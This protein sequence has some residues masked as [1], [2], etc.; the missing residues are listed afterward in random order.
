[1]LYELGAE[2]GAVLQNIGSEH[3]AA[4]PGQ[5][6]A[7]KVILPGRFLAVSV[8]GLAEALAF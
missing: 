4:F 8:N 2:E 7:A 5:A 1:M 3:F 6:N